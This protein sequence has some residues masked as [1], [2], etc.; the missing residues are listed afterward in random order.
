MNNFWN[1]TARRG[2]DF[3]GEI[4]E[5]LIKPVENEHFCNLQR[6]AVPTSGGG[7]VI[8]NPYKPCGK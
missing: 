5:S 4:I 7:E 3:G 6:D 1:S 8:E 2:A